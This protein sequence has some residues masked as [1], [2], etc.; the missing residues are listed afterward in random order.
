MEFI[1]MTV[2]C[3]QPANDENKVINRLD[4]NKNK[5]DLTKLRR[6]NLVSGIENLFFSSEHWFVVTAVTGIYNR[7]NCLGKRIDV[8][9]EQVF[10]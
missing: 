2:K 3:G 4:R 1:R 9:I 5:P 6:N 8:R 7:K 10:I